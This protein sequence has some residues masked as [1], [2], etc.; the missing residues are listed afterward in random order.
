[1]EIDAEIYPASTADIPVLARRAEECGF[2]CA[3]VNETRH[4]P[5]IQLALAAA[6]TK[7]IFLGS[8][9]A[10]AFT[11]SPTALAY[12][13]WDLQSLSEGR[14]LLGLGTQVKGH[15]ERRFGMRWESPAPKMKEVVL[16]LKAVWNCWQMGNKLDFRGEYFSLSL[17][18]PFFNPGPIGKP[19]IP[20]FVAGVNKM[21]CRVAGEVGDGILVHPLHTVRYLREEV[22]P[23]VGA[24]LRKSSRGRDGFA[25][26]VS[27]FAAVGESREERARARDSLREQIA[28]YASTRTYRRVLEL[29]GWGDVCDRLH[30][31]SVKGEWKQMPQEVTDDMLSEFVVEGTWSET[32]EVLRRRYE[33][34]ADR[35][36]I[37]LPFD[38]REEWKGLAAGFRA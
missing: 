2:G 15:I 12:A 14:L 7:S 17:M 35:L 19:R 27:V 29:H 6:A 23:A 13:S 9:V 21:M 36:R 3:W 34:L 22:I 11:R 10:L 24:G 4:D 33:G 32:G 20:V 8:S 37:Y 16:A 18:P 5:F 28:F 26:A 31:R 25:V 1:M 38:G 30:A